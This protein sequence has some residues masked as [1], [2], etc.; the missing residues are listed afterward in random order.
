MEKES[1]QTTQI[2]QKPLT[3]S[4]EKYLLAIYDI[5][6]SNSNII[7][8]DVSKYLGIGGASTATAIRTLAKKGLINY[9]P[10]GNITLTKEGI[11]LIQLKIYRHN[12]ISTFLNQVLEIEKTS[13]D[14][15]ASAIEYSMTEDVLIKFVHFLDF[16][17]QCSCK[18]PKWLNSCKHSLKNG[19]ISEKCTN[20]VSGKG[21]CKSCHSIT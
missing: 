13:A 20:C 21:G 19:Q 15:N 18:E 14:K 7:V 4:L 2:T 6:K 3:Q 11:N 12:T 1:I 5:S 8:K 9:V 16:M 17:K 10:Y